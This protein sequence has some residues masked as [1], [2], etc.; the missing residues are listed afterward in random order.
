MNNKFKKLTPTDEMELG[1]YKEALDYV[2]A[3]ADIKNVAVSGAYGAGKSSVIETYKK[4]SGKN[5]IH[6][7]LA[8]FKEAEQ[9]SSKSGENDGA[10]M[11]EAQLEGKIINQLIHQVDPEQIPLTDFKIKT[12]PDE[13]KLQNY[14]LWGVLSILLTIF[15]LCHEK[16]NTLLVRLFG[17]GKK[18]Y[19]IFLSSEWFVVLAGVLLILLMGS[20][21]HTLVKMQAEKKMLKKIVFKDTEIEILQESKDSFFDSYLNEVLYLFEHTGADAIVFED[22]DRYGSNTIFTKLREIRTLLDGKNPSLKFIYLLRDDMF[23]NA[24]RTKFFDFI[25]P[26]VPVIDGSNSYN[27]ILNHFQKIGIKELFSEEF[28]K[29]ISVFIDDMRILENI[30]NE[31]LI[32]KA[33]IMKIPESYDDNKMLAM[34]VY[35]NLFPKDF[36]ELQLRRGYVYHVIAEEEN[37]RQLECKKLELRV[38]EIED[39][40]LNRVEEVCLSVEELDALLFPTGEKLRVNKEV[41]SDFLNRTEF[42][43]A[44]KNNPT[45]VEEQSMGY[46]NR[47]QPVNPTPIFEEMEASEEYKRRKENIELNSQT[48]KAKLLLEKKQCE[49]RVRVLRQAELKEIIN[50]D[51]QEEIFGTSYLD[52]EEDFESVRQNPYFPLI[53]YLIREGYLDETYADYMTYFYEDSIKAEDRIFL[54]NVFSGKKMPYSYKLNSPKKVIA[55]LAL[56]YY[57][58]KIILNNDL[59]DELLKSEGQYEEPLCLLLC[60][61]YEKKQTDF[62][63]QYLVNG[64]MIQSFVKKMNQTWSDMSEWILGESEFVS[65]QEAYVMDTLRVC[66]DE[67]IRINDESGAITRY[68]EQNIAAISVA[69]EDV[70]SIAKAIKVLNIKIKNIDLSTVNLQLLEEI[71]RRHAYVLNAEMIELFHNYFYRQNELFAWSRALTCIFKEEKQMLARYID[72]CLNEAV[73]IIVEKTEVIQD[74]EMIILR[75]LNADDIEKT[76]KV[77]YLSRVKTM[78]QRLSDVSDKKLW[79]TLINN[80]LL[81]SNVENMCEYYFESGNKLDENLILY[82]NQSKKTL[83]ISKNTLD[84][85]YGENAESRFFNSVVVCNELENTKYKDLVVSCNRNYTISNISDI[86]SDKM[87]ILLKTG[88]I[89]ATEENIKIL[90]EEYP[91]H[92]KYLIKYDLKNYLKIVEEE[93]IFQENEIAFV[94]GEYPSNDEEINRE[95]IEIVK[96]HLDYILQEKILMNQKL[97]EKVLNEQFLDDKQVKKMISI[98]LPDMKKIEIMDTFQNLKF[99]EF[100]GLFEGKRPLFEKTKENIMLL[101]ALQS[102]GWISSYETDKQKL[103]YFRAYGKKNII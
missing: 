94:L 11:M 48:N 60:Q 14:T 68:L 19:R 41:E 62:V 18:W 87:Q 92:V 58:R 81:A 70:T 69:D 25:I 67:V 21:I 79:P 49:E 63:A 15:I 45:K 99:N 42:I 93:D 33:Q 44:I 54:R 10:Q 56:K 100:L 82:I 50:D 29:E 75:V 77:A 74:D 103:D 65:V 86:E 30:Q 91:E 8:H 55:D 64:K 3:E 27:K 90:R 101:D 23:E 36:G 95:I 83:K 57:S 98:C 31:F 7:S 78:I 51:N 4:Q 26:V 59:L 73:N 80:K 17:E 52:K 72:S 88:V 61:I 1:I 12:D 53:Q 9:I 66:S 96:T 28:L 32:Y 2:F 38:K 97:R 76:V 43:N 39:V 5:F 22:M 13:K 85:K 102:A 89:R 20:A 34:I 6:I 37:F 16:W 84:E 24:D 40:L 46:A 35:T 47:W 71:Y